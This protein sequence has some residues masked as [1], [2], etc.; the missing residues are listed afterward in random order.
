MRQITQIAVLSFIMFAA[1]A[2]TRVEGTG[3]RQF[4]ITSV[5]QENSLGAQSY[6]EVLKSEKR[7]TDPQIQ[8]Y[9]ERVGRR[10]AAVAPDQGFTYEF[11]VLDSP[12]ANA[13]CL[14]GGKVAVYTGI[15][16]YCQNEAGLAA[17]MGHEIGHAIARH[18]GER[19]SQQTLAG[20]A[21][22][23]LAVVLQERGVSPTQ[24]NL[25]MTAF[26]VG[27]QIGVLLPFSREH[28]SEADYLG[29]TYMAKAGY[30]PAEAAKFWD[31]FAVL[32]GGGPEFLST[33]PASDKRAEE[34]R[35][36]LPK[37]LKLYKK[38]PE[39]F[40]VG[41]PVPEKYRKMPAKKSE[42]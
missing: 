3:R 36:Q 31:R 4:L 7:S 38:A 35:E 34:L 30:D 42:K 37:A 26:G 6:Q 33:H 22:T 16:P 21:Q 5:E 14:P 15:L 2:C 8:A 17:V 1:I 41:E 40:G 9:V 24:S 11:N 12:E 29:L 10:L 32:G 13:F 28:E 27:T 39:K 18:G 20:G 23:L 19:M 25:A